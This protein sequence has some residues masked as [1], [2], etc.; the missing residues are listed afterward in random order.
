MRI[1]NTGEGHDRHGHSTHGLIDLVYGVG[2]Q[3][4]LVGDFDVVFHV[5]N[6]TD[7]IGQLGA[8]YGRGIA[9]GAV[10]DVKAMFKCV[11]VA[12]WSTSFAFFGLGSLVGHGFSF[13]ETVRK[14]EYR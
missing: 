7:A 1:N 13:Q 8:L 14:D 9:D 3:A 4:L 5:G 2:L 12:L 11:E 6:K 10:F